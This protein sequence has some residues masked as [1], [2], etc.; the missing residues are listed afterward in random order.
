MIDSTGHK[1]YTSD[2]EAHLAALKRVS[3]E[4]GIYYEKR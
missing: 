3:E 1:V 2:I 4:Y